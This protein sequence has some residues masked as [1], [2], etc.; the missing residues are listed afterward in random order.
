MQNQD[1]IAIC[2][3]VI[4]SAA[5][6][7]TVWQGIVIRRHNR[8]SVAPHVRIEQRWTSKRM[9]FVLRNCG[10]GPA[11]ISDLKLKVDGKVFPESQL[12]MYLG[13]FK[14]LDIDINRTRIFVPDSRDAISPNEEINLMDLDY[15]NVQGNTDSALR[16]IDKRLGISLEYESIYE[17]KFLAE[18]SQ[19]PQ[20][21]A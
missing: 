10:M 17:E 8:M 9:T 20:A 14:L 6:I 11:I 18:Y 16:Q 13:V 21:A 12:K 4:A 2:S 19:Q 7:V 5:L 3:V 15:T 1:I